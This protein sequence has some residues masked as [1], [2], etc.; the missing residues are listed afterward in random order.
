MGWHGVGDGGFGVGCWDGAMSKSKVA[1]WR[2]FGKEEKVEMEG[3]KV[4]K[5]PMGQIR[6]SEV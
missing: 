1:S 3:R 4:T 5:K 6:W 2:M